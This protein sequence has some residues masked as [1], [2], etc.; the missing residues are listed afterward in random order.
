MP[1]FWNLNHHHKTNSVAKTKSLY[2]RVNSGPS[3]HL[4]WQQWQQQQQQQ[5]QHRR[6]P[7]QWQIGVYMGQKFRESQASGLVIGCLPVAWRRIP[8]FPVWDWLPSYDVRGLSRPEGISQLQVIAWGSDWSIFLV[9]GTAD[10]ESRAEIPPFLGPNCVS[11]I[12]STFLTSIL[13]PRPY[14]W[15]VL[16]LRT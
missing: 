10:F 8:D 4:K 11:L 5:E 9:Q 3:V 7:E 6:D 2:S 12:L 16:N 14:L 1:K 13:G 15:Y